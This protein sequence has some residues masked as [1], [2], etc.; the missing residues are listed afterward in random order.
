MKT[1]SKW[2]G[3]GAS[4]FIIFCA[5]A[6]MAGGV[7][8]LPDWLDVLIPSSFVLAALSGAVCLTAASIYYFKRLRQSG[9]SAGGAEVREGAA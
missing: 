7:W 3:Y 4:F 2:G 1:I 5:G 6:G 9:P 8:N